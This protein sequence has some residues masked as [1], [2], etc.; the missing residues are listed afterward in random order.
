MDPLIET[1]YYRGDLLSAILGLPDDIWDE[2]PDSNNMMVEVK[3]ELA[4]MLET[5]KDEIMPKLSTFEYK[6]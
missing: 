1:D 2:D 5:V 3:D 6:G 4:I